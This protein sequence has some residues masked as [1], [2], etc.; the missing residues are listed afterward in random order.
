MKIP[1][2]FAH[3]FR[4]AY[5]VPPQPSEAS[6]QERRILSDDEATVAVAMR[7]LETGK[8]VVAQRDKDGH[9]RFIE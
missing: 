9:L 3:L 1:K 2:L 8:M 6:P 5:P 4:R 7:A